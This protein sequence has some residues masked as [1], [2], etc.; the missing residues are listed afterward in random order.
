MKKLIKIYLYLHKSHAIKIYAL[1]MTIETSD[2]AN[3]ST[4]LDVSI[5]V[6]PEQK[7]KLELIFEALHM[8]Q[9]DRR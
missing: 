1:R 2:G 4:R 8:V 5:E 7:K 9:T 3:N 6:K